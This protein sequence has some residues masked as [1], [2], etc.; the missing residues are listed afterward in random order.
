M[1]TT[2]RKIAILL[3]NLKVY[4]TIKMNT[5]RSSFSFYNLYTFTCS[6][7]NDFQVHAGPGTERQIYFITSSSLDD[8][9]VL[10]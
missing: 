1:L 4:F 9:V 7:G 6:R 8:L 5:L 10:V 2:Y 3:L